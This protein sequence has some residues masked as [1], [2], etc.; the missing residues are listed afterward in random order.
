MSTRLLIAAG[1]AATASEDVPTTVRNLVKSADEILVVAPAL[2][3]RFE[4]LSSAT[5]TAREKADQRLRAVLGQVSGESPGSV[6]GTVGADDPLLVFE[7]AVAEFSPDHILIG[8]R[9]ADREGWQER[10]LIDRLVAR[11]GLPITVFQFRD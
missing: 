3:G 1:Q 5:D 10:G 4:W 8:L 6:S 7:D 2:P 9:A 11:F